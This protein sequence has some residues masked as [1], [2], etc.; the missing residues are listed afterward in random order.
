MPDAR[1]SDG[2]AAIPSPLPEP[3]RRAS[4]L[5]TR[6]HS[7]RLIKRDR[8][9]PKGLLT[10]WFSSD[11]PRPSGRHVGG[12]EGAPEPDEQRVE[13]ELRSDVELLE[14]A[15][16][17]ADDLARLLGAGDPLARRVGA[18]LAEPVGVHDGRLRA[19]RDRDQVAVPPRKLLEGGEQLVALAA[20]LRAPHA[21]V[22][23]AR[24]ELERLHELLRL[25][26]RV[27]AALADPLEQRPRRLGGIEVV[28]RIDAPGDRQQ[29]VASPACLRIEQPL[30]TIE[31]T[32]RELRDRC[33]LVL[34]ET[35]RAL[36]QVGAHGAL[37]KAAERDELAARA[38]R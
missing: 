3:L 17:L 6:N 26:P 19:D 1:P 25:R 24:R 22:G 32:G 2:T 11:K 5:A 4:L 28:L 12:R 29:R 23:V 16:R 35:G 33:E 7:V 9:L 18:Q 27:R 38:N 36:E 15:P 14:R 8:N 37:R 10:N 13:R 30:G 20:P 34:R 31:T 21:L